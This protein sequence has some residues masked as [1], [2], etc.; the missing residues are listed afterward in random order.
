MITRKGVPVSKHSALVLC[1]LSCASCAIWKPSQVFR[2]LPGSPNYLLRSPDSVNTPFPETLRTYNG[3]EPARGWLNLRM[4]MEFQ[5]EN[6]Y[7]QKGLPKRGLDGFVGTETARYAMRRDGLRLLAARSLDNRPDDQ[8]PVKELIQIAQTRHEYYR[9]F[10]AIVFKRG[11]D[12]RNSVLLGADSRSE[13]DN[14]AIQ[15]LASPCSFCSAQSTYCTIFPEA[16]TVTIEMEI[17][18]NGASRTVVWGSVLQ[19]I[20]PR[21]REVK[22]FRPYGGRSIP[23]E[24]D[25][26]DPDALHLPLLPGDR[27][28]WN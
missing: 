17:V 25:S 20:A 4:T 14:L 10:F 16:C 8:P 2:V 6:A 11:G 12:A 22:V 27:V 18:A 13:L 26:R 24:L 19:D 1:L 28:E 15:L 9:F 21:A 7:Y 5:I 23:V 3:Y